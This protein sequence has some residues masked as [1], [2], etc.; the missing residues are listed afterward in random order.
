MI[1][2]TYCPLPGIILHPFITDLLSVLV[3]GRHLIALTGHVPSKLLV[4]DWSAIQILIIQLRIPG[5][6]ISCIFSLPALHDLLLFFIYCLLYLRCLISVPLKAPQST[7]VHHSLSFLFLSS[8]EATKSPRADASMTRY[9]FFNNLLLQLA[10]QV[11]V[12]VY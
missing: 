2:A 7:S 1:E 8:Y 3:S 9:S 5:V 12:G 11:C 10:V 4:M 6:I